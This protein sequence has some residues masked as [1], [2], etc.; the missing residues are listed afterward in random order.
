MSDITIAVVDDEICLIPGRW[1]AM[2]GR[3]LAGWLAGWLVDMLRQNR[4]RR[5]RKPR[6]VESKFRKHGT[7]K[8]DGALRKSTL[9]IQD[10]LRLKLRFAWDLR[11]RF[12][13]TCVPAHLRETRRQIWYDIININTIIN[14]TII[15]CMYIH[16][17]ICMYVCTC[18]YIYIYIHGIVTRI[19]K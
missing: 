8:L 1:L 4:I 12:G 15:I 13:R 14:S 16:I 2:P 5:S 18:I 10:P 9:Y 7:K 11:L 3:W 6:S 19:D 17:Y